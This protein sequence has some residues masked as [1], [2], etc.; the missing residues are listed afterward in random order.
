M[1]RSSQCPI[2]QIDIYLIT[3]RL[4]VVRLQPFQLTNADREVYSITE[5]RLEAR[6]SR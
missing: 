6:F 1:G 3:Y 4:F 2:L 5:G